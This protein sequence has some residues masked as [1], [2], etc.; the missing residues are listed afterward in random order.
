M[1]DLPIIRPKKGDLV[2]R[3]F[4]IG[5][6]HHG[7]KLYAVVGEGIP[8]VAWHTG[9]SADLRNAAKGTLED[10]RTIVPCRDEGGRL[11][12]DVLTWLTK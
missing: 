7:F 9:P 3:E 12:R 5:S 11:E 4:P 6:C 8:I 1:K 2:A 10:G